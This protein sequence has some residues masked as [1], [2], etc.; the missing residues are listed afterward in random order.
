M[1]GKE[2]IMKA[3]IQSRALYLA[4]ANKMPKSIAQRMTRQIK[5]FMWEG[6]RPVI[7]WIDATQPRDNKGLNLPDIEARLEVIQIMWLKKYLA[8]RTKRPIWAFVTDQLV[9]K[10]MQK[11]P[12]VND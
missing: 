5:S 2:L 3:L 10:H 8:P 4:T 6:K 11:A 12:T 1:K 9:F 7:N